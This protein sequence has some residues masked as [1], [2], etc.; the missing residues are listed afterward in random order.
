MRFRV[1]PKTEEARGI[2]RIFITT[3]RHARAFTV[4]RRILRIVEQL[5]CAS[6]FD[7]IYRERKLNK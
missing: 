7:M 1:E 3:L 5:S 6:P 2:N 4:Y